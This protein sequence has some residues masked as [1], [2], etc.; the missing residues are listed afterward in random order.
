MDDFHYKYNRFILPLYGENRNPGHD[1]ELLNSNHTPH[2]YCIRDR[3]DMTDHDVYS[4]DPDGCEDADDAFSIYKEDEKICLAI[5]IADPTE[6]I[7]LK[8]PLWKDM[9]KRVITR[10]P[11]N[12][13]PIHMI[14]HDI[15]EMASLMDNR[16]GCIKPAVTVTTEIDKDTF[17]PIGQIKLL[18]TK[19]RV[20]R[21]NSLSYSQAAREFYNNTTIA[22]CLRISEELQKLRKR[23]TKAVVLNEVA[24]SYVL[25]DNDEPVLYADSPTER[26]MKHMIAEFAIFA[27]S[28]I[29]EY[30]KIN[31]KSS[32]LYRICPAKDWLHTL[33]D[34]MSGQELLNE[35]ITNGI[36]A[37]YMSSVQSHDL[38]GAPEYVHFTSPIRRLTDCVCHYLLKYIHLKTTNSELAI[39]FTD[40][41]LEEY[42]TT[43][44]ILSRKMKNNQY[45]DTKFRMIQLIHRLILTQEVKL[46]YYVSSYKNGFL[47]IIINKLNNHSIYFSYTLRIPNV[48]TNYIL[49]QPYSITITCANVPNKFDQG[50]LPE[51][52][53][54]FL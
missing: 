3:V 5:H 45:T 13:P 15:M 27:N 42:S 12:N 40:N 43:C 33:E 32:G 49:K 37:E 16:H 39:P 34:D 44:S 14:P 7:Q 48:K 21:E 4:I 23:E 35:I 6:Y 53:S 10:Y 20:R 26:L 17:R 11:S 28:F 18:F 2:E 51:L 8:S 25:F 36:K 47:N 19:I 29:G 46:Q 30:L 31:F 22:F 38:V 24:N 9:E 52:D 41:Q 1:E 54:I 50:T